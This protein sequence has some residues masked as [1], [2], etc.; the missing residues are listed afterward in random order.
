MPAPGERWTVLKPLASVAAFDDAG[1][2]L[3]PPPSGTPPDGLIRAALPRSSS[4][5]R[6]LDTHQD[7]AAIRRLGACQVIGHNR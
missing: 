3:L 4:P 6:L 1:S 5:A 7:R 2:G